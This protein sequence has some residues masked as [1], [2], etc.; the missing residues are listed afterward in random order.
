MTFVLHEDP[1]TPYDEAPSRDLTGFVPMGFR[2]D[3]IPVE[4]LDEFRHRVGTKPL[5][6]GEWLPDDVESAPTI[7]MKRELLAERRDEV[8]A[9]HP[10]GEDVAEEAAHLVASYKGAV[11]SGTGIDALVEAALLVPDDLTVLQPLK[12]PEGEEQLLFVA[13]VVCSPSRWRLATKVGK[14]MLTVHQPVS[15]YAQH[16]GTPVDTLLRRL[17]VDRPLWRSNWTLEDHPALFQPEPPVAPLVDDPSRLWVRME[18]ETLRRLPRTGGV[19]FTIRG[20]QQPL[21][22][23]IAKSDERARTMRALI[24]RLPDD[25]AR[26]KSILPYRERVLAWL[27]GWAG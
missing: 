1:F 10:G 20:F 21:V 13:G 5:D 2:D 22:D 8:V 6:L 14:D 16:I 9:I 19:L 15:Q 26:Y 25:V 24:S 27:D 3:M 7:A 18:R 11:I 23:F 17:T 4:Q 12:S